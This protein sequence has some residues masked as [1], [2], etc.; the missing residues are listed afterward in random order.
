MTILTDEI[1][2]YI[3]DYI[4]PEEF[5]ILGDCNKLNCHHC[6]PIKDCKIHD[7]CIQL[8]CCKLYKDYIIYS[9]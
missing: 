4:Y 7:I 2:R 5:C 9:N 3:L 1:K 8:G 6:Y